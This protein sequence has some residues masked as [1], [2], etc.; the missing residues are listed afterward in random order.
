MAHAQKPT[1]LRGQDYS[2][3]VS[4]NPTA[5]WNWRTLDLRL[6]LERWSQAVPHDRIHVLPLDKTAAR[7][8][9]WHR[10]AGLLGLDSNSYDLSRSFPNESMGVVEAETRVVRDAQLSIPDTMT[11]GDIA[12]DKVM[13]ANADGSAILHLATA[14]MDLARGRADVGVGCAIDR[15]AHEVDE[16]AFALEQRE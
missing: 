16:P 7:D 5:V 10:F 12:L 14:A 4:D 13:I 11:F 1:R 2:Q 3:V 15:V 8:E 9:I 6:V